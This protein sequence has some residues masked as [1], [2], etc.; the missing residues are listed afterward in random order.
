MNTNTENVTLSADEQQNPPTDVA[1]AAAASY[2]YAV[3]DDNDIVTE[4]MSSPFPAPETYTNYILIDSLDESLV[5]KK[6]DRDTQTFVDPPIISCDATNVSYNNNASYTVADKIQE[7]DAAIAENTAAKH[8]H[9]NQAVLDGITAEKVAAWDAGTG[10]EAVDAYTKNESDAKYALIGSAY[11]KEESDAKYALA[12]STGATMT[13][14]EILSALDTVDGAGSGLDADTIDGMEASAFAQASH[15]H[16]GFATSDH[17]HT[18]FANA[19]HTHADYAP[20]T[21]EHTGYAETGHTHA[22][23]AAST[24][25]HDGYADENHTHTASEVGA[26]A[27]NHTHSGY[28]SSSHS[29]SDYFP[30]T[31]GTISGETNFSGGLV[32]LKGVQAV[33]H[34]G[35]QLVYGSNNLPTRIA[36][37]A[38]SATKTITVDSDKRLKKDIEVLDKER[39]QAFMK[40][41]KPVAFRYITEA[42]GTQKHVGVLAQQLIKI[43]AEIASYFVSKGE[44]GYYAVDYTALALMAA[45]SV[46]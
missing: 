35:S 5:G 45:L 23:Y 22:E 25:S 28:A 41:V 34:S 44:D 9:A 32:R 7:M 16:E 4:V 3:L 33:F 37:N 10:T 18:G 24:H 27:S 17:T 21:H 40:E 12:G 46:M 11:T 13:G 36:G 8:A 38:I 15:T 39:F 19:D 14:A 30:K 42:D 29:H 1:V 6:Y 26:A 43:D 20:A 31:G 2:Y